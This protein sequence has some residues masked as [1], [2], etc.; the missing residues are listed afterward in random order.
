LGGEEGNALCRIE[1][2]AERQELKIKKRQ[3]AA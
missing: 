2:I 3:E 1:L